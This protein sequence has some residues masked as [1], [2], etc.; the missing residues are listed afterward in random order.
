MQVVPAVPA[1]A[2]GIGRV[3]SSGL[4]AMRR[5]F[6][7]FS[8]TVMILSSILWFLVIIIP[9]NVIVWQLSWGFKNRKENIIKNVSVA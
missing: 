2:Q 3:D 4:D 1:E 6:W 9:L 7:V 8:I 5:A